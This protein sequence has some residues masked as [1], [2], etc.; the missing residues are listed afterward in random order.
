MPNNPTRALCFE[1]SQEFHISC[2]FIS[3][4]DRHMLG[5][6]GSRWYRQHQG[7]KDLVHSTRLTVPSQETQVEHCVVTI[8]IL[9]Q[10][11]FWVFFVPFWL[12]LAIFGYM[13]MVASQ[14]DARKQWKQGFGP[15][16]R[17]NSREELYNSKIFI[18]K[19]QEKLKRTMAGNEVSPT[20]SKQ[21][22][23]M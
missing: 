16:C 21:K 20:N 6:G 19:E 15:K 2:R 10:N 1:A 13:N 17:P 4:I 22:S 18:I 3:L 5:N 14:F 12:S 23:N 11:M 9:T 7:W 8:N